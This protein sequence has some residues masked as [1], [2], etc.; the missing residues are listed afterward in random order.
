MLILPP[1]LLD[2]SQL[3]PNG[4]QNMIDSTAIKLPRECTDIAEVRDEIDRID[5]NIISLIA[6]RFGY[7]REVVKYKENTPAGIEATDRRQAVIASRRQWAREAGLNPDVIEN[8]YST[9][10]E[11]FIDEEKK[12]IQH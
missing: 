5:R 10:I 8:L 6:E 1:L 12:L 11:Y 2:F 9:L 7:V 3:F 4:Q